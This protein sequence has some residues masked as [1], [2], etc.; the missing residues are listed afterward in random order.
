MSVSSVFHMIGLSMKQ[1]L[2]LDYLF[3]TEVSN[4]YLNSEDKLQIHPHNTS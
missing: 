2:L 1:S 3:Y 4:I